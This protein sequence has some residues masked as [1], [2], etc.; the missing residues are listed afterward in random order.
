VKIIYIHF[1]PVYL[2]LL[3]LL[4][5]VSEDPV[6]TDVKVNVNFDDDKD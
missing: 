5:N 4:C 3:D 1:L 2:T 6:V